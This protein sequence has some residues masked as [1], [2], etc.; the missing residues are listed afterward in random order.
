MSAEDNAE[1]ARKI[2]ELFNDHD[3]DSVLEHVAEGAEVEL[4]AEGL[5]FRG[6]EGFREMMAH[7]KAPWP[8]GTVEV[9][10]QF[11]G[12]DGVTNEC[13]YRGTHTAPLPTPDGSEVPPTGKRIELR[14]CEVWRM[15]AGKVRSL[16]NYADNLALM[17]KLGLIP[18]PGGAEEGQT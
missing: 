18:E 3:F 7:F 15:E 14:F 6:R 8:D 11:A 12:E 10:W 1:I 4:Y 2:Y 17:Q 9:I 13:V 16:H 5:S